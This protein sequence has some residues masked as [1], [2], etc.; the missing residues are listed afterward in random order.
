MTRRTLSKPLLLLFLTLAVFAMPAGTGM[1]SAEAG[2]ADTCGLEQVRGVKVTAKVEFDHRGVDYSNVKSVMEIWIPASWKH[3]P[4]L[5]RDTREPEYRKALRCLLGEKHAPLDFTETRPNPL[6]VDSDGKKVKVHYEAVVSV[7]WLGKLQIGPW[8][9]LSNADVWTVCLDPPKSLSKATWKNVEVRTGGP[10]ALS[11]EPES[12]SGKD[13][14]LLKWQNRKP[15]EFAVRFRPPTAQQ[16]DAKT[17]SPGQP[18]E[19]VGLFSGSSAAVYVLAGGLL[20]FAGRKLRQGLARRPDDDERKALGVL[21]S[22][23]LLSMGLGLLV[24]MGDNVLGF[25]QYDEY[26]KTLSLFSLLFLGIALCVFGKLQKPLM[27]IACSVVVVVAGISLGCEVADCAPLHVSENDVLW[28]KPLAWVAVFF[29]FYMGGISSVRRVLWM[30]G[31][32][33]PS[34]LVVSFSS[35][36]SGLTVLWAY[37]VFRRFWD[38]ISWLAEIGRP[39]YKNQLWEQ[40]DDW[41]RDFPGLVLPDLWSTASLALIAL[42]PAATLYVCRAE[43]KDAGSFTPTASEQLFLAVFF[44]LVVLPGGG[45]YFGVNGS[46]VTIFLGFLLARMLISLGERKAVLA[47][48]VIGNRPLGQVISM[49]DRPALLRVVRRY[50]EL[51][52]CLHHPGIGNPA[53]STGA[54]E[55]IEREIDHMDRFLP[56]GVRLVDVAFACGPMATWWENARRSAMIACVV[57][58]PG[59]GVMY[60]LAMVSSGSWAGT[61]VYPGGFIAMVY[62][63]LGWHVTWMGAAFFMGALWRSLPVRYGP[64]KAFCVAIVFSIPVCVHWMLGELIGQEARGTFV[65]IATFT[66]VMTCTGLV[67]DVQT[68]TSE[69]RYWPSRASLIVYIYQMPLTAVVF[70]LTQL[71]SLATIWQS[72][73]HGGPGGPSPTP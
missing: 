35:V 13:G 3:A 58:L 46:F 54:R 69:R 68:F 30:I 32:S 39:T 65:V 43:R 21:R 55:A 59:T 26:A 57:G 19:S 25:L 45:V 28:V 14:T 40:L 73:P 24:Y 38:R 36:L 50:R 53:E 1:S 71:A 33:L 67:M 7:Q 10:R 72:L 47:Q 51:Q 11:V 17:L 37:L 52:D 18:W 6:T 60:W 27:V 44:T 4:N 15:D 63:I 31:G 23:A 29:V 9:L 2:E 20:L 41:W 64:A 48:P 49:A 22:W 61:L 16:W 70:V 8:V 56:E 34:W 66:S 62:I 12:A 5:L 42:V